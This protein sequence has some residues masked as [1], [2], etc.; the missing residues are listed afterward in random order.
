M[1]PIEEGRDGLRR[2]PS[3]RHGF[4]LVELLV[5]ITIIGILIG[6]L[7]PAVQSA[8]EAARKAQCENNVKQLG[9]AML[10]FETA[11]KRFPSGGWG[12][13]W[14]P[15]PDRGFNP[16]SQP[17]GWCYQTL[18]YLDQ[19][20]LFQLGAGL[21]RPQ[22]Y[23]ATAQMIQTLLAFHNCPTRRSL[24]LV[25]LLPSVGGTLYGTNTVAACAHTDYAANCGDAAQPWDLSGPPDLATGDSWTAAGKWLPPN[26]EFDVNKTY[27]GICYLR[28][29]IRS[30][31]I[32]DG[33]S[34]TYLIGEKY[35][36]PDDYATG[37]DPADDQTLYTGFDNDN[38]RTVSAPAAARQ[39]RLSKRV[40]LRQRPQRR[41]HVRILRWLGPQHQLLDRSGNSSPPRQSCRRLAVRSK[42][43]L[44][45]GSVFDRHWRI[46]PWIKIPM[47][48]RDTT[49]PV[50]GRW[51]AGVALRTIPL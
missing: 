9:T 27:S 36:N 39:A 16:Q 13:L 12:W 46:V 49:T 30:A 50:A 14:V 19:M 20:N 45:T 51:A 42:Q 31:H 43:V 38:H 7:L 15:D 25:P 18:P 44:M 3:F 1:K 6:L 2:A 22:K 24:A 33:A 34:N 23:A 29:E 48:P 41:M 35:L 47:R 17:G 5:V 32:T 21:A 4:T 28:S 11:N 40:R 10:A 26:T 37:A 8:R